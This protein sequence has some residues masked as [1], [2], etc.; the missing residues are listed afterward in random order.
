MV[1][2]APQTSIHTKKDFEASDEIDVPKDVSKIFKCGFQYVGDQLKG[3]PE[4]LDIWNEY[5]P[6]L[7][8]LISKVEACI[9]TNGESEAKQ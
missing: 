5:K 9:K 4:L 2:T 3:K 7:E 8:F 1:A 6:F